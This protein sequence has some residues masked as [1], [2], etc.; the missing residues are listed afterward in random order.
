M[1]NNNLL[2]EE[3]EKYESTSIEEDNSRDIWFILRIVALILSILALI[4]SFSSFLRSKGNNN[5]Y[6]NKD[7]HIE[8]LEEYSS[9]DISGKYR[10]TIGV[11]G[12]VED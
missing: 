6:G 4:I 1:R 2:N 10:V 3:L 12:I 11:Y 7:Y 5:D 9:S 8:E